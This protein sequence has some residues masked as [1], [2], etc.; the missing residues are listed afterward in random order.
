MSLP[1]RAPS[2]THVLASV[3]NAIGA[4]E[5]LQVFIDDGLDDESLKAL[6][7]LKPERVS[8]IYGLSLD[9]A[10]AFADKCS[11]V[12]SSLDP[13][14][15]APPNLFASFSNETVSRDVLLPPALPPSPAED[16][17][18]MRM[19]NFEMIRELGKGGFGTVYEAK[20]L[21]DRL[22]VA[23]KIVKDPQNAIHAIREGQRLRRVKHKNIVLMHKV[24]DIS[25]GLCALEMEVVSGG[26]LSKHLESC[27]RRPNA[28]L[29]R[30]AVFRFS[31]Q[32][33]EALVYL[34]DECKWLHGDIKPQNILMLCSPVPAD[35]SAVDYSSAE[36]KLADFGLTKTLD[37]QSAMSSLMLSTTVGVL[38]GTMMYLSPEA[39][40]G[41]SSGGSY[42]RAVSD[43]LWSACLVIAEMD[44]GMP[45][46][47]LMKGPALVAIEELLTRASP[48]LLPL[49]CAVLAVP[50][51]ASRCSSA[52]ELLRML[53]ASMDPLFK[54]QLHDAASLKYTSVHPASSVFLEGAFSANEPITGLPL[55]APLDLFFDI[56]AMLSSPTAL[57]F[58]T[59]KRSGKKCRI[60]RV[61]RASVLNSSEPIPTWQE[62]VDGKEWLQCSPAMCAKLDIDAKNPNYVVDGARYRHLA[63]QNGTVGNVQLP[64]PIESKPY[65]APAH[66]D[67]IAMLNK[68]VHDSLPEWDV[69]GMQQVVNASLASKYA[70]YRH[71]VAARCNGNPNERTMFHFADPAVMTKIWQQ[72]EGHDPRLSQWADVGKGSYFSTHPII[73]YAYKF[74]LYPSPPSFTVKPEPPI[75]ESMQVFV[76]LV[77]LGNVA[78]MGPGCETC[79]SPAWEAWKKEPPVMPKPTRP[80]AMTLS[81]DAAEERHV[82]DLMQ[83]NASPRYDSVKSTGG[84]LGTHPVSTNKDASGRRIC[85]IMH[86]RLRAR[87]KEW[88]EQFVLFEAA[89]SYPMFIATLTQNRNPP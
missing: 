42:D 26:D 29:P 24:H 79:T 62:L 78:D 48:E 45:I 76:S 6:S 73:G 28:C 1:N 68:R 44:T 56:Q 84:D 61:L 83:V 17:S 18:I 85:E 12:I 10:T 69:S 60:R 3:L 64:H 49:L 77:C 13:L 25:N 34:H 15:S 66:A 87:A 35:G 65:L 47:Q 9:Q 67:D 40:Q 2:D 72:G 38:K 75:G 57:G 86:P 19:L 82:L 22:K 89:A 7:K 20:N 8:S 33:L 74:S 52:A 27:R 53:D 32:L 54:W 70:A 80:P 21:A 59:E 46:H 23:L 16:S 36:I 55:P 5:Y 50:S 43:D 31:R 58:Q 71:R 11:S 4:S 14:P 39:M 81:A 37:Q 63:L 51:A 30:D 41:A 88:G